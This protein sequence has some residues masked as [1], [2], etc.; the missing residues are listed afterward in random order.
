LHFDVPVAA[1][2]R[3]DPAALPK[4]AGGDLDVRNDHY[5]DST[6][7]QAHQLPTLIDLQ[8]EYDSKTY[9]P[10]LVDLCIQRREGNKQRWKAA[11]GRL[12]SSERVWRWDPT[13]DIGSDGMSIDTSVQDS[14]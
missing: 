10:S 6:A 11:G 13:T 12:G 5:L 1:N 9:L 3:V 7:L 14:K 4:Q 2:G 8:F